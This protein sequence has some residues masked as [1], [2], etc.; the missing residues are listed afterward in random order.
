MAEAITKLSQSSS[1]ADRPYAALHFLGRGRSGGRWHARS[2]RIEMGQHDLP[3][4]QPE[5]EIGREGEID[6]CVFNPSPLFSVTIE[7]G[8]DGDRRCIFTLAGRASG[9]PAW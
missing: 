6:I 5:V 1:L 9:S 7:A 4:H 2:K 8:A 3:A